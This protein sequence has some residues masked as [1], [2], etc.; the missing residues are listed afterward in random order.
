MAPPR[1]DKKLAASQK[2]VAMIR[3]ATGASD[4]DINLMLEEC[5]Y[6]VNEATTRL[7]ESGCSRYDYTIIKSRRT[8]M[9][10]DT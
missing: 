1:T 9:F 2:I 5:N 8:V 6:D 4:E 10:M 7:I 3:E